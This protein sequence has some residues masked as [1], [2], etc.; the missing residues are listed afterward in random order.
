VKWREINGRRND[1]GFGS[2]G[3]K[4]FALKAAFTRNMFFF[5]RTTII[6]YS[7]VIVLNIVVKELTLKNHILCKQSLRKWNVIVLVL[8][9]LYVHKKC[10]RVEI[11]QRIEASCLE[12]FCHKF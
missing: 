7:N 6:T 11:L 12:I 10:Y 1:P 3:N 5:C 9:S 8:A 4:I 2:P